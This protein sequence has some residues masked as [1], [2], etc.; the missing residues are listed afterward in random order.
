[1]N[2]G[3]GEDIEQLV[4]SGVNGDQLAE[5]M[6]SDLGDG[7]TAGLALQVVA[8]GLRLS[9]LLDVDHAPVPRRDLY[10]EIAERSRPGRYVRQIVEGRL[11]A[12]E[13]RQENCGAFDLSHG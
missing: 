9:G 5:Q 8:I 3:R 2:L 12:E 6:R 1:M 7:E 13:L 11:V 4:V 10:A